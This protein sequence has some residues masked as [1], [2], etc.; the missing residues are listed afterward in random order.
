MIDPTRPAPLNATKKNWNENFETHEV[1]AWAIMTKETKIVC[2]VDPS[3]PNFDR[4]CNEYKSKGF[5]VVK[6]FGE[7]ELAEET[8]T[9]TLGELEESIKDFMPNVP[10][11]ISV[12]KSLGFERG[13]K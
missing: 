7:L 10:T 12:A 6:L 13:L 3:I 11:F 8:V 9:I 1:H 5:Y 2:Y 4:I